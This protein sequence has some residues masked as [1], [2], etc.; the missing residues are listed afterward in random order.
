MSGKK[1]MHSKTKSKLHPRNPLRK[2]YNF[3]GYLP[4]SKALNFQPLTK[5][6]IEHVAYLVTSLE[7]KF[8]NDRRNERVMVEL[9]ARRISIIG[10][11]VM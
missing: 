6:M 1:K 3:K 11:L 5:I 2:R 4:L 10:H 8:R 9:E 7:L